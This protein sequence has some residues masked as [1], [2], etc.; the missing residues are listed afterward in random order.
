V[1]PYA[2]EMAKAGER[3]SERD[4]RIAFSTLLRRFGVGYSVRNGRALVGLVLFIGSMMPAGAAA[5]KVEC[6]ILTT[7]RTSTMEKELSEAVL[8]SYRFS[9][10]MAARPQSDGQEVAVANRQVSA[11]SRCGRPAL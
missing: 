10:A 7:S 11:F 6:R 4:R 9:K 8:S 5:A 1:P 3:N 2:S